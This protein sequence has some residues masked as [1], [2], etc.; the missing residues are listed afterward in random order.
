MVDTPEIKRIVK[1]YFEQLYVNK[2]DK[3]SSGRRAGKIQLSFQSQ[4]KAM[5]KNTQTTHNC[6]HLTH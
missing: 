2:F 1:D 6:T 4:R 3:L 5:P